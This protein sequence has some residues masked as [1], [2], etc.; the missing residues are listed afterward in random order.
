LSS[1]VDSNLFSDRDSASLVHQ[2]IIINLGKFPK[3]GSM[4][5]ALVYFTIS[6]LRNLYDQ[7]PPQEKNDDLV[8][9]RHYT[10]I[11]EAHYMLDFN[12]GPLKDLIAVGRNKGMSVILATQSMDSYKSD[13]FDFYTNAYYPIIM[14][15]QQVNSQVVEGLFGANA[16]ETKEIVQEINN[17]QLGEL[18]IK[19]NDYAAL[20]MGKRY[21][22]IKVNKM[23]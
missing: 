10:I 4:A 5:K 15:Q 12:N 19:D 3:G 14:K 16:R 21:K 23:I 22:K 17:L 7:L 6:K 8:Q 13:F 18:I 9:L 2:S 11:D 20:G 1:M